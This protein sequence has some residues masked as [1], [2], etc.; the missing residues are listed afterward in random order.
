MDDEEEGAQEDSD[1]GEE[2]EEEISLSDLPQSIVD[3]IAIK[4]VGAK[5]MEADKIKPKRG[6]YFYDVE[7][8]YQGKVIE[9]MYDR[10]GQM[11]GE[12]TEDD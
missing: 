11:I 8:L 4:F 12:E 1:S 7:M 5:L 6:R 9:V 10:N 3:A 2:H